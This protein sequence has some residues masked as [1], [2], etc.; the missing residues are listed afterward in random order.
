V[1][2]FEVDENFN[3]NTTRNMNAVNTK[4]DEVVEKIATGAVDISECRNEEQS[5]FNKISF[6]K[7]R[8]EVSKDIRKLEKAVE[9]MKM[10]AGT[11]TEAANVISADR[12]A[13]L[14]TCRSIKEITDQIPE[15]E[16]LE[17][18]GMIICEVCHT[19][20]K[21]SQDLQQKFEDKAMDCEFRNLKL[22]LCR[23]TE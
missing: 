22:V 8:V 6:I 3:E 9:S 13:I 1:E 7:S 18:E 2:R 14:K 20:F 4:L 5:A 11:K 12:E 16:Y 19:K 15:F 21:Y 23:H 10:M 17:D